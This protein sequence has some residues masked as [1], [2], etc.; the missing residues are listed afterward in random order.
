SY[1]ADPVGDYWAGPNHILPTGGTARFYSPVSVDNFIKKIGFT[2]YTKAKL[3][4]E[5]P[6]IVR[7]AEKEELEAH[8]NAV[9]LRLSSA[10]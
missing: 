7:L 4:S 2:Y 1:S 5:G 8:A 3:L 10:T 6:G 9:R